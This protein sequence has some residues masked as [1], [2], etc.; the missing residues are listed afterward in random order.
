MVMEMVRDYYLECD[1]GMWE[2]ENLPADDRCH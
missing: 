2:G 1:T